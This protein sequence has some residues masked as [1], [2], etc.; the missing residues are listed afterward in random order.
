[1]RNRSISAIGII[2]LLI[3]I[4]IIPSISGNIK[5]NKDSTIEKETCEVIENLY[6]FK[7]DRNR[8]CINKILSKDNPSQVNILQDRYGMIE[9]VWIANQSYQEWYRAIEVYEDYI[10]T[11]GY[12]Y[13]PENETYHGIIGKYD[14]NDGSQIW[15][16]NL[17]GNLPSTEIYSIDVYKDE[18]YVTGVSHCLRT[19]GGYVDALICKFD[20]DG[21]FLWS[22]I[23][24][25][26]Y[27]NFAYSIKLHNDFIYTCGHKDGT[28]CLSKYDIDGNRIW[29]KTYNIPGTN[30]G[31]FIDLEIY[32]NY[33][34][35]D[36]Q[37]DSEDNNRQDLLLAKIDLNGELQWYK[38]WNDEGPQLGGMIHIYDNGFIYVA[39]ISGK[40]YSYASD[41]IWKIDLDGHIKW[42]ASTSLNSAFADAILWNGNVYGIG[43]DRTIYREAILAK[44]NNQGKLIWYLTYKSE[45]FGSYAG[46]FTM[47]VYEDYFYLIGSNMA[48]GFIMKY[49]IPLN[50]DNNKPNTPS[51]PSGPQLGKIGQIY[52]YT[53]VATDPDDDHLSYVFSCGN[54][55]DSKTLWEDSGQITEGAFLWMSGGVYR[56]RARARDEHGFVSSWSKPLVVTIVPKS[57]DRMV[58]N[59]LLMRFLEQFPL[60]KLLLFNLFD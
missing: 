48:V 45:D 54:G 35:T 39:G 30:M 12:S 1:M 59:S 37:T 14:L 13:N 49:E 60:V 53:S 6:G 58:Q 24:D 42:E 40:D 15:M 52:S 4:S 32:N 20:L 36:G 2:L 11:A 18:I 25:D 41:I 31:E 19:I 57:R 5:I 38:E 9:P 8:Y 21:N 3:G 56:V 44:F 17:F 29:I 43:E 23:F 46:G 10:Y 51:K 55:E 27:W 50:P 33:I 7:Y 47:D 26:T 22:K 16:R 34:Y 28:S